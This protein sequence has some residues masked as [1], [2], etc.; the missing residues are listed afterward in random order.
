P[1]AEGRLPQL[2]DPQAEHPGQSRD[3]TKSDSAYSRLGDVELQLCEVVEECPSSL[4]PAERQGV[5]L[6]AAAALGSDYILRGVRGKLL[7]SGGTDQ[8][9]AALLAGDTSVLGQKAAALAGYARQV[10]EAPAAISPAA[11]ERCR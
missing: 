5:A 10:A 11:V 8:Q 1:D 4:S 9:A 3:I 2:Y 7:A 6:A